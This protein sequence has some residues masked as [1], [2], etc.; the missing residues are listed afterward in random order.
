MKLFIA[1]VATLI[2]AGIGSA[3][4][5]LLGSH[6]VSANLDIPANYTPELPSYSNDLGTWTY[7]LNITPESGGYI[8]IILS[9]NSIPVYGSKLLN[10]VSDGLVNNYIQLG[11]GGLKYGTRTYQ[12]H[13]AFEISAPAQKMHADDG[14]WNWPAF[15]TLLYQPDETASVTIT[16]TDTG[17]SVFRK[18]LN[19]TTITKSTTGG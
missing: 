11:L 2:L 16:A 12:G 4:T 8:S 6:N 15:Y 19:S 3:G 14:F 18:V 10:G 1:I 17:E 9:D 7:T 13:D 5:Y